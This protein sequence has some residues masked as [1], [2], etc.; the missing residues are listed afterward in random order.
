MR[1]SLGMLAIYPHAYQYLMA[2]ETV[3]TGLDS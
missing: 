1:M 3:A 2:L